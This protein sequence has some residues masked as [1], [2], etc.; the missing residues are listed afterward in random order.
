MELSD[1]EDYDSLFNQLGEIGGN[2]H[3]YSND[4]ALLSGVIPISPNKPR[5]EPK[6]YDWDSDRLF[7]Q[8]GE[9]GEST[10]NCFEDVALLSGNKDDYSNNVALLSD[11]FP[12]SFNKPRSESNDYARLFK[13]L[14][15][16][17]G[18]SDDCFK[19]V[20]LLSDVLPISPNKPR[21]ELNDYDRLFK[22]LAQVGGNND[23]CSKDVA[24]LSDVFPISSNK[25]MSESKVC[26][27]LFKNLDEVGGNKDDYSNDMA[28]LNDVFPI[29]PIKPGSESLMSSAEVVGD[30]SNDNGFVVLDDDTDKPVVVV[31]GRADDDSD[32][33]EIIGEK[34]EVAFRDFPHLRHLCAKFPFAS[35]QHEV[36]YSQC[37]CYVCDSLAPC[38]HW[39]SGISSI[40][41]S[42]AIDKEEYWRAEGIR[43]K[44][45]DNPV[46]VI[47]S[48]T[49][50]FLLGLIQTPQ[51]PAQPK[52]LPQNQGLSPVTIN[53]FSVS[54]HASVTNA[55]NHGGVHPSG[56][57]VPI[58]K[59]QT[60]LVSLQS[61]PAFNSSNITSRD[62]THNARNQS[63][64]SFPDRAFFKRPG[65]VGASLNQRNIG[66]HAALV[67][68]QPNL[69]SQQNMDF[70]CA[71]YLPSQPQL[72][73]DPYSSW[74]IRDPI[75][76][77]SRMPYLPYVNADF[78]SAVA[79]PPHM[80]SEQ[81]T[82]NFENFILPQPHVVFHPDNP[83]RSQTAAFYQSTAGNA[84]ENQLPTISMMSSSQPQ[85]HN[86]T[87]TLLVDDQN[88][89]GVNSCRGF[90]ASKRSTN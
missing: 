76:S 16:E 87:T 41:H 69:S 67:L 19:D 46:P 80:A 64:Q 12:T 57:S 21:S 88:G 4:M 45:Y 36:H 49:D 79:L 9:E 77:Q 39:G 32:D 55:V 40:G 81:N 58:P 44:K 61:H 83:V 17:G 25:Q 24:L 48:I 27:W 43:M 38:S 10:D 37:H 78:V 29:S 31:N 23:D 8:L 5:S 74:L 1:A 63:L 22:V 89:V 34:D 65:L 18:N 90:P 53:P 28:L 42:H 33:L 84:F 30:E 85:A 15:E 20:A 72:Q 66:N 82:E 11:V 52:S 56:F 59:A 13:L 6:D 2:N 68:P 71:N 70:G 75:Q 54:S 26:D 3:D 50:T 47:P 35:T 86:N 73:P 14:G 7:K 51:V 62:K 60:Q